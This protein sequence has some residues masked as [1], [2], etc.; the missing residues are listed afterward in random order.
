MIYRLF[1]SILALA[2]LGACASRP[3]CLIEQDY[4]EAR[5]F[6]PLK[7]PAGMTVPPS[8][9]NLAIPPVESGPVAYIEDENSINGHG[10]RCL[11]TPPRIEKDA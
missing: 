6:P 8:N 10:V 1:L 2:V 4:Q 5:E 3:D 7:A 9:P 11:E